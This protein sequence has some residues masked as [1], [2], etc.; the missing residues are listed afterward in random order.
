MEEPKW[1][2]LTVMPRG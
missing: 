2:Y 1:E